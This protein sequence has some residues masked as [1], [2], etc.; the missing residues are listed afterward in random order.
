MSDNLIDLKTHLDDFQDKRFKFMVSSRNLTYGMDVIQ[1]LQMTY[2]YLDID[3][4]ASV[5]GHTDIPS[6]LYGGRPAT[7]ENA[8][9]KIQVESL[10]NKNISLCLTLSNYYFDKDSYEES[11][12]LLDRYHRKGNSIACTN[13]ELALHI[14]KDF[15]DYELKAS[16]IKNLNTLDKVAEALKLY[17][18]VT[19]PMDKND[20]DIF[21]Q[22]MPEKE[23]VILFANGSCA[24]TCPHRTCYQGISQKIVGMDVKE[25]CSKKSI[26]R[27][28]KGIVFFDIKKFGDMGY[29]YF[30]LIPYIR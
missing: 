24:Y 3:Q 28:E 8:L 16:V 30:K 4:I 9:S 15:P 10:T 25:E 11:K 6:R 2:I 26:S 5:F 22:S 12:P 23:R 17:D 1:Y 14:K 21:L 18:K 27:E 29:R 20:D 7:P 19:I 13:D